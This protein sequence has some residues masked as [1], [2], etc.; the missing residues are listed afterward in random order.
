MSVSALIG[1]GIG[2]QHAETT[3]LSNLCFFLVRVMAVSALARRSA[4][5][6]GVE[7]GASLVQTVKH[8]GE[9]LSDQPEQSGSFQSAAFIC[10]R[11]GSKHVCVCVCVCVCVH[12]FK[13]RVSVS[14]I[15]LVSPK[16]AH[17]QGW[18]AQYGA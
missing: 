6:G 5:A 10:T 2:A 1:G 18:D 15:P 14:Y 7:A 17:S 3:V 12:S 9:V 16:E 13:S 4:R 8:A 11:T